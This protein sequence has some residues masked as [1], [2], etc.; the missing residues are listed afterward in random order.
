MNTIKKQLLKLFL[1]EILKKKEEQRLLNPQKNQK[2]RFIPSAQELQLQQEIIHKKLSFTQKIASQCGLIPF[3]FANRESENSFFNGK[4]LTYSFF[5]NPTE[6]ESL[7]ANK[8]AAV[9]TQ[10]NIFA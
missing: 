5:Q 8:Q 1:K 3:Y 6:L 4:T 9:F 10:Q 7:P 2:Q